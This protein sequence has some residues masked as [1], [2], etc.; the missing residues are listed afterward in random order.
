MTASVRRFHPRLKVA[1]PGVPDYLSKLPD[2]VPAGRVLVHNRVQP[3]AR[4]PGT[5]GSRI[6]LDDPSDRYER[7]PCSW[8]PEL[9]V[10]Y[11][12]VRRL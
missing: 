3:P 2:V 5:R 6:R 11:R 4:R 7:C 8:A 10:H 12:V 1:D 9:G